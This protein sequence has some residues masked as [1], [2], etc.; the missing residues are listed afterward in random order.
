[1]NSDFPSSKYDRQERLLIWN[2]KIIENSSILIAGVGGTG[3]EVCKNLALMGIGHLILVDI[4]TIEYSNLNRQMLFR[5][6]DIGKSKVEITKLRLKEL[7]NP[8]I[9]IETYSTF[10]QNLP[11]KIFEKADIIA[12]CVDNFLARQYLNSIAIELNKPFID[13]ATDGYFGQIRFIKRS[14][15]ACLACDNPLPPDETRTLTAP[16][17]LVGKPRIREHCAWKAL[18][19]FNELHNREPSDTSLT[20][21]LELTKL[22]NQHA[23]N[24]AFAQFDK[25]ELLQLILFHV[26]SLITVNAVI[27]GIQSQEII[28]GLFLEKRSVFLKKERQTLSKLMKGQRFRIPSYLIYS[29]LTGTVNTF[30]LIPDPKCL[31][32]KKDKSSSKRLV[33]LKVKKQAQVGVIIDKFRLKKQK[34]YV[35][36]RGNT[37]LP[38]EELIEKLLTDGDRITLSSL[39]DTEEIR[40]KIEFTN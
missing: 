36:F 16:C 29:A 31:V 18:Y 9:K 23:E 26:P 24:N 38:E 25:K 10:I 32:C 35:A 22:A 11:Q 34:E 7:F 2:Q 1:M 15:T 40:V 39:N 13:S 37:L 27:S 19:E 8:N 5:E 33:K 30:S 20:D 14:K 21:I 6:E 3:S 12:G 28:K 17:T 4:D